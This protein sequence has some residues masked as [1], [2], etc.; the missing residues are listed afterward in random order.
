I[1]PT[2]EFPVD[3]ANEAGFDNSG[4]SLAMSPVLLAKYL[5]AARRVVSHLVLK[6]DGFDFSPYPAVTDTDRDRY[7]V[8]RII[9]F[10]ARHRVDYADYFLAAWGFRNRDALEK[11][12][13][14]LHDF[15]R[16]AGLSSRYLD[17]VWAF[18]AEPWPATSAAGHVQAMWREVPD[19]P[20]RREEARRDCERSPDPVI[21]LR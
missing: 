19:D 14:S 16:E 1:R 3:P 2:R 21:R 8:E 5:A 6:P 4:E 11:P 15:A 7:C 9:A 12:K 10:Y 18:L 17:T 20:G 13:S